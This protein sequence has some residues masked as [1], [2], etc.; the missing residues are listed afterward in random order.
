VSAPDAAN[1]L[2]DQS[3]GNRPGFAPAAPANHLELAVIIPTYNERGNVPRLVEALT[4]TLANISWEA[5]FVDD[6]SPDGTADLV[7]KLAQTHSN[8]RILERIGRRGL[9]SAC[10]EGMLSTVAPYVAVLDADLQHDESLL[11]EMLQRIKAEK[12]DVVI[13]SRDLRS[14]KAGEFPDHRV[15]LSA[16]GTRISR[17]V[18]HTEVSDAMSGFFLVDA[19]FF[20]RVAPRL[21]GRGFKIL[22]DLL[23]T[24]REPVRIA[25]E[26]YRFRRREWGESK[27]EFRVGA[28][29]LYLLLDKSLGRILPTRFVLFGFVG[30]LGV[31]FHLAVLALLH[32][33]THVGFVAAQAIATFSAMTFN[34]LL[35][36][37]LT[38]RDR[39]LSGW[40]ILTGLLVFDLAC[41]VGALINLSVASSL[42]RSHVVWWLAGICGL[43]VS[44]VWNYGVNAVF[45]WRRERA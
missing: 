2:V 7:R 41:S 43:G 35:N 11:P 15:W 34:F 4:N 32:Y 14:G 16:L 20:R 44:S 28:E 18:C 12:L 13:A 10:I 22:V 9:A 5:I 39:R 25:E 1:I 42:F 37:S 27:L 8:I 31:I 30:S 45:T 29:Y 3:S 19:D 36:N 17:F 38:F 6:H 33:R 40:R 24:S 21:S 26:P 23:A